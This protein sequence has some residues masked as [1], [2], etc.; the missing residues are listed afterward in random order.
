MEQYVAADPI[1]ERSVSLF[2]VPSIK[3]PSIALSIE[4]IPSSILNVLVKDLNKQLTYVTQPD[5]A[6]MYV[7]ICKML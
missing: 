5:I 2:T 3:N 4:D 1:E 6:P 7:I